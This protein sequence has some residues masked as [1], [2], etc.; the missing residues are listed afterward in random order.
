MFKESRAFAS[1]SVD[2]LA[3][4][5]EFYGKTLGLEVADVADMEDLIKVR[6][7]GGQPFMIYQKNN[8][9]PATFTVLNFPV[10]DVEKAVEDLKKAGIRPEQYDLEDIKTDDKGIARDRNYAIAWFKDPAGNIFSVMSG[11]LSE[12]EE[13]LAEAGSSG[14]KAKGGL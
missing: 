9:Q 1:F 6:T 14:A 10:D 4:A 2:D 7:E 3:K 5:K 11:K 8:H 13:E 12:S